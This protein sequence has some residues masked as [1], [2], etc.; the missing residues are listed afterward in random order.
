MFPLA[1]T[2]CA[3]HLHPCPWIADVRSSVSCG[4]WCR[5]CGRV[6]V[7]LVTLYHPWR[8]AQDSGQQEFIEL[9]A[10]QW[11]NGD[12]L[13]GS[14]FRSAGSMEKGAVGRSRGWDTAS[15]AFWT[16]EQALPAG[17]LGFVPFSPPK[18]FFRGALS[19]QAHR[20]PG[21]RHAVAIRGAP[22]VKEKAP[23]I[24]SPSSQLCLPRVLEAEVFPV[25][26]LSALSLCWKHRVFLV[27]LSILCC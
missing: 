13:R 3:F 11:G 22:L 18:L 5:L 24:N 16:S 8:L 6:P 14:C 27:S 21:S 7:S 15:R 20:R 12:F 17:L 4:R 23:H 26:R 9:D 25:A 1:T 19:S 10:S 2:A